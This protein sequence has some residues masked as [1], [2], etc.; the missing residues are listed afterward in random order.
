MQART[1]LNTLQEHITVLFPPP[2]PSKHRNSIVL[3]RVPTFTPGEKALVARWRAYL[4]WEESNPLDIDEK[5]KTQLHA[6]IGLIY[7]Q[8]LVKLRF[9]P[10][11][12]CGF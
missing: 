8:A 1:V 2:P 7:R 4:K 11:I 9:S 12:W 3:P 10:E 6:R 5:D